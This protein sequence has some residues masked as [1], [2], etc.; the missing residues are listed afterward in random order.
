MPSE[1]FCK[2]QKILKMT[3]GSGVKDAFSMFSNSTQTPYKKQAYLDG[4]TSWSSSVYNM[5]WLLAH[6]T[7]LS[8]KSFLFLE[9]L[10][11]C[12]SVLLSH[13]EF[14]LVWW[15][16]EPHFSCSPSLKALASLLWQSSSSGSSHLLWHV[17]ASGLAAGGSPRKGGLWL[18]RAATTAAGCCT[19][20]RSWWTTG[21]P[22]SPVGG[23]APGC[24]G[25]EGCGSQ[26]NI[27]PLTSMPILFSSRGSWSWSWTGGLSGSF[28]VTVRVIS[29]ESEGVWYGEAATDVLANPLSSL[30]LGK[31]P[32]G[33]DPSG[34][35][36]GGWVRLLC[37]TGL[38]FRIFTASCL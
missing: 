27:P 2:W 38:S 9:L 25:L 19:W 26:R 4:P 29:L 11:S 23:V 1:S 3:R 8:Y 7:G 22:G 14:L 15:V 24:W 12:S 6:V 13:L 18:L 17:E 34:A 20:L 28:E 16:S 5:L 31:P 32:W 10:S 36:V 33:L 35:M 21:K 37:S 30:L